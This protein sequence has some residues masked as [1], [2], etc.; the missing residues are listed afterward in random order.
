[1]DEAATERDPDQPSRT[2]LRCVGTDGLWRQV[3]R[4]R[5]GGGSAPALFLD[6]DG[7]VLEET[8]YLSRPQD[9][10]LVPGSASLIAAANRAGMPVIVV[11]NQSGIGRRIHGWDDFLAVQHRMLELLAAEKASIDGIFACPHHADAEDPW[12]HANH[13]ARKPNPL[14]LGE[15]ARLLS[16][17][18]SRSWIAGDRASDLAAGRNAGLQGGLLVL[19]RTVDQ[20]GELRAAQVLATARFRVFVTPSL[21]G[22]LRLVPLLGC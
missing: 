6:R 16:I 9:V 19:S 8:G 17:N 15:A 3:L 11:S 18:L 10:R 7:S 13:P 5:A 2:S 21:E 20:P 12:R 14:M 22:V 1:V 4:H